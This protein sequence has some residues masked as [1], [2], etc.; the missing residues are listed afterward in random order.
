MSKRKYPGP[1]R[2]PFYNGSLQEYPGYGFDDDD[3]GAPASGHVWRD[4][5]PFSATLTLTRIERGRSAMR[6]MW[7]DAETGATYPMFSTDMAG[8]AMSKDGVTDG[9]ASGQWIVMKRGQNYGIARYES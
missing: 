1:E 5:E 3:E 4:N 2:A 9:K 6:F 8:L 7:R